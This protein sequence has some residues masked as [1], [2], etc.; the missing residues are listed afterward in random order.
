MSELKN[1]ITKNL[2]MYCI[3]INPLHLDMI[4]KLDYIPVGLSDNFFTK[5]WLSDKTEKNI[6]EKNKYYGEYTFHYWLWQNDKINFDDWIGFCQYRK[7]WVKNSKN[8]KS[9]S[10]VNLNNNVLKSI[11]EELKNYETIVGENY[12]INQ[13]RLSKFVKHNLG[14][15]L[16][17]PSLFFNE[18]KRTIKFQFDMMH[19]H[20]N[21]EKAI[22]L[23]P[24]KDRGDFSH[25]VNSEVSFSP[26]NMFICKNKKILFK[27]YES[28]FPWLLDCEKIF[29]FK[30]LKGYGLI[31]IYGFLAER[32]LSYWFKK[33]TKYYILPIHFKDVGDYI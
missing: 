18:K 30:N 17:N 14:P 27:Y 32:Y 2:R 16:K 7:F 4:K 15:M 25:Y 5:D 20:G 10:F 29:G 31:R 13:F 26:Y 33:Y 24:A 6:S 11:P 3:S 22:N 19:G 8:L 28:V 21:L 23:L 1:L 9:D 12:L